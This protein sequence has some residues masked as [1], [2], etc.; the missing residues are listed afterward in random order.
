MTDHHT[1]LSRMEGT[2][3][4]VIV[5]CFTEKRLQ[6]IQA[7]LSSLRGQSR[8]PDEILIV[9]NNNEQLRKRLEKTRGERER[10]VHHFGQRSS[11][12]CR[13][14][15]VMEAKGNIVAFLD[16]DAMADPA[17]LETLLEAFWD[18]RTVAAGGRS[19][20][21]W[22]GERPSWF[23]PELDWI[24]GGTY[25]GHPT[26]RGPV[27]NVHAHNMAFRRSVLTDVQGF[28]T[29]EG[30]GGGMV[31]NTSRGG[32]EAELC[33]R[34]AKRF[35]SGQI[36]YVPK[37]CIFHEAGPAK[38][39]VGNLLRRSFGEGKYKAWMSHMIGANP[40]SALSTERMYLR[41]I[42]MH[43]IPGKGLRFWKASM[44]AQASAIV[45]SCAAVAFGYLVGELRFGR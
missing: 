41:Y 37:A 3:V 43:S 5:C 8:Q 16:D 28:R 15:G 17:W 24:L 36:V 45:C 7:C 10:V 26:C 38:T 2:K 25:L 4:S 19:I 23:P 29:D 32:E 31:G 9:V 6:S 11:S 1:Q 40:A 12:A 14:T 22:A 18:D 42:L 44:L 20:P 21:Q 30:G 35:P 13:N 27:R 34:I 39:T 33:L